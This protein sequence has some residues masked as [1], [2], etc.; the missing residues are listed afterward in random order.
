MAYPPDSTQRPPICHDPRIA[1]VDSH[2][3]RGPLRPRGLRL[4]CQVRQSIL[5]ENKLWAYPSM[6]A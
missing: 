6:V 4:F 1:Y 5:L 2:V 3:E